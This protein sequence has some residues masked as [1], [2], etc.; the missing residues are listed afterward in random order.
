MAACTAPRSLIAQIVLPGLDGFGLAALIRQTQ[1][2]FVP[3][4]AVT[5][6]SLSA[7]GRETQVAGI[8]AGLPKPCDPETIVK[9]MRE[10]LEERLTA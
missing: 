2:R 3:I 8:D 6:L 10:L 7:L 5:A 4:V 1:S 9:K